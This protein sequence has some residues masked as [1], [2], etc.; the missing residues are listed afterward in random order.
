MSTIREYASGN[1]YYDNSNPFEGINK[2]ANSFLSGLNVSTDSSSFNLSDYALIKKGAY[3]KLMKAYYANEKAEKKSAGADSP[4]KLAIMGTSA[5][6]LS[7]SAQK[8]TESSLWQKKTITEKDE[9]TG[10]TVEKEDYDWDSITKAVKAFADDYNDVVDNAVESNS[11][12]ILRNA[13]WMTKTT[14]VNANLLSKVGITI[15]KGNKLEVDEE[16]LK[17]AN[18][19]DLKTLF[20]GPNSYASKMQA[21]GSAINKASGMSGGIYNRNGVYANTLSALASGKI[22]TRE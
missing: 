17:K 11:K 14:S 20:S 16:K 9:I 22:D 15:G 21:K 12:D 2:N 18:V 7:S 10:E 6:S 19:S 5:N 13:A 8:L 3:G 1:Y 4:Q